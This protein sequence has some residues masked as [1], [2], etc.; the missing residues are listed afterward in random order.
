MNF[1]IGLLVILLVIAYFRKRPVSTKDHKPYLFSGLQF[2]TQDFYAKVEQVL[3]ERK[4]PGI[5][6]GR[7]SMIQTHVLS[8]RREYLRIS[9]GEFLFF[10]CG[11]PFGTGFFVSWWLT[12]TDESF[13]NRI[14]VISKLFGLSRENKTFYQADTES[15]YKLAV[16]QAVKTVVEEIAHAKGIRL[17][18]EFQVSDRQEGT[19]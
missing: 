16:Q 1:I 10:V 13:L 12:E 4:I 5:S 17:P 19:V 2:S 11:A 3:Q 9:R 18:W 15:M 8:D 6:F 14:P 7:E